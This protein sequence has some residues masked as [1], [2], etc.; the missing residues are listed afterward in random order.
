MS[1]SNVTTKVKPRNTRG[2]IT[3]WS[4]QDDGNKLAHL[5]VVPEPRGTA[6]GGTADGGTAGVN[7]S[8][9]LLLAVE[10]HLCNALAQQMTLTSPLPNGHTGS[11]Q[12]KWFVR[13]GSVERYR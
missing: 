5:T 6:D 3:N 1:R 8:T 13:P 7:N 2:P 12:N 11:L 4:P 9:V 10:L